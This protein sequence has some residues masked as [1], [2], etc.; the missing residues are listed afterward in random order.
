MIRGDTKIIFFFLLFMAC[1]FPFYTYG[2]ESKVNKY[3]V[4]GDKAILQKDYKSAITHYFKGISLYSG[5]MSAS[6]RKSQTRIWDDIGYAYLQLGDLK[7]AEDNLNQA[8]SFHP[9]N[10]N[11]CFYLAV[12]HLLNKDFSLAEEK[13]I[14]IENDIFF[15]DSWVGCADI[16]R[17]R[18][19]RVVEKGELFRIKN[20]KGVFLERIDENEVVIHLDAFNERNEGA[21][22]YVQGI[23]YRERGELEEA[24]KK[25]NLAKAARYDKANT[26]LGIKLHHRLKKHDNYLLVE[27]HN[28]FFKVL[29]EGRIKEAILVLKSALNVDAQSFVI[30]MN[31]ALTCYDVAKL[32]DFDPVYLAMAEKYCARAIWVKDFG[33]VSKKHEAGAYDLMGN[34]Y[35]YQKR[36]L[37]AK[38]EFL[39]AS[40][41]DPADPYVRYNLG[42]AYFD[43]SD[44]VPAAEEWKKAIKYEKT[45]MESQKKEKKGSEEELQFVVT[46]K[47]KPISHRAHMSLGMLYRKQDLIEKSLEHYEK[48]AAI[49]PENAAPYLELG[50]IYHMKRDTE[51]ALEC[52]IKYLYHGGKDVEE[53]Q[54]LID[55]LKK[56]NQKEHSRGFVER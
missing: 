12:T 36:Y 26:R 21:F 6:G 44:W 2:A 45:Y 53:T 18:N 16:F 17:K 42:Q 30:N 31:L 8:L 34:I 15:E 49:D 7:K 47:R 38:E 28:M 50:K 29:K 54:K 39:R 43:L 35:Y 55:S 11:T 10:Y 52:Y 24:E 25:F 5:R 3:F 40:K 37:A 46:V 13:L 41:I 14:E 23:I 32:E 22:Y 1:V 20:E 51:R 27:W 4:M 48:A 33:Y 9:F 19:G 56:K